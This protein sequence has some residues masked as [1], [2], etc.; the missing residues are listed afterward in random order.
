MIANRRKHQEM[1]LGNTEHQF[2][3]LVNDSL[4]LF[5]VTIDKDLTFEQHLSSICRKI[6]QSVQRYDYIRQTD[7][8]GDDATSL[9]GIYTS[10]TVRWCGIFLVNKILINWSF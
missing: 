6:K 5:V 8:Y 7:V 10:T 2:S 4:H 1:T 9:Q 3:F